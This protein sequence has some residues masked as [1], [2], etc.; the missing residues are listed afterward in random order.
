MHLSPARVLLKRR[1]PI[2]LRHIHHHVRCLPGC[3]P[4]S[5]SRPRTSYRMATRAH[6]ALARLTGA[7]GRQGTHGVRARTPGQ[8]GL[9]HEYQ[10][11]RVAD[12]EAGLTDTARSGPLPAPDFQVLS[13][14]H[15]HAASSIEDS[16]RKHWC[17]VVSSIA[18]RR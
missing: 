11:R 8:S 13:S 3:L 6:S 10:P 5:Q 12:D 1:H 7:V 2:D 4:R 15:R 9:Q 18:S 14:Q 17:R 16:R